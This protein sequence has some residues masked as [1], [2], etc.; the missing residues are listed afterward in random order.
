MLPNPRDGVL[1]S[2]KG[3][4]KLGDIKL[5]GEEDDFDFAAME[6]RSTTSLARAESSRAGGSGLSTAA[7]KRVPIVQKEWTREDLMNRIETQGM[8]RKQ[9]ERK[10]DEMK[11]RLAREIAERDILYS[12]LRMVVGGNADESAEDLL[13]RLKIF[14]AR[15]V[16]SDT[17][18]KFGYTDGLWPSEPSP[19]CG[20]CSLGLVP[21]VA[22]C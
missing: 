7:V 15:S 3:L 11:E 6:S 22:C 19:L 5:G 8:E 20:K 21:G 4:D 13:E 2:D 16:S 18:G 17:P 9:L 14:V 1:C 12:G 10:L